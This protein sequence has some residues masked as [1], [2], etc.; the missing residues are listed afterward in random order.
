[1]LELQTLKN[2][3]Q[4]HDWFYQMSN[5]HNIYTSGQRKEVE[6]R[7]LISKCIKDEPNATRKILRDFYMIQTTNCGNNTT[8]KSVY[9]FLET[10]I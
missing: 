9:S 6:L 4:G 3:L 2:R 10:Y 8:I 1:M 7:A 5:D